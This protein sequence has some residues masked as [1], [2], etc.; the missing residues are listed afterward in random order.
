M[1]IGVFKWAMG[2]WLVSEKERS[3]EEQWYRVRGTPHLMV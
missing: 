1:A 3:Q 2:V